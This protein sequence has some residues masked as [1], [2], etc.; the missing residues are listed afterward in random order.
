MSN[1]KTYVISLQPVVTLSFLQEKIDVCSCVYSD[2][3]IRTEVQR[4]LNKIIKEAA[5]VADLGGVKEKTRSALLQSCFKTTDTVRNAIAKN[6]D[7]V[8]IT[9]NLD[10]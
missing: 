3:A 4:G 8:S 5:V 7:G 10:E 6:T 2:L 9:F 1:T